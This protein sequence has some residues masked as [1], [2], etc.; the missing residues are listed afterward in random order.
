MYVW[1][2]SGGK[3]EIGYF[4][5]APLFSAISPKLATGGKKIAMM[6]TQISKSAA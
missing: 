5:P 6:A 4:N 2:N 1:Q 3:A